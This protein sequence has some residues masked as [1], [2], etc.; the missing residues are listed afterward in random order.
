M[1]T[2]KSRAE[3]LEDIQRRRKELAALEE[4]A[5]QLR[6]TIE[7][8]MSLVSLFRLIPPEILKC[9]LGYLIEGDIHD[10]HSL[11]E[12]TE[13]VRRL[14]MVNKCWHSVIMRSP[15]FWTVCEFL[16]RAPFAKRSQKW[17]LRSGNL[18]LQASVVFMSDAYPQQVWR[19]ALKSVRSRISSLRLASPDPDLNSPYELFGWSDNLGNIPNLTHLTLENITQTPAGGHGIDHPPPTL[20][21]KSLTHFH[22]IHCCIFPL[23]EAPALQTLHCSN[24][25]RITASGVWQML[26]A[27][28]HIR[29]ISLCETTTLGPC[30]LQGTESDK[31]FAD[32]SLKHLRTLQLVPIPPEEDLAGI[33]N[34][35]LRSALFNNCHSS[36]SALQTLEFTDC[37]LNLQEPHAGEQPDL[38]LGVLDNLTGLTLHIDIYSS[39]YELLKA[40]VRLIQG[41]PCLESLALRG[42]NNSFGVFDIIFQCLLSPSGSCSDTQMNCPQLSTL[43]LDYGAVK[44]HAILRTLYKQRAASEPRQGRSR[45]LIK[46]ERMAI[47]GHPNEGRL[48]SGDWPSN[49]ENR[50]SPAIRKLFSDT[51]L[52][53]DCEIVERLLEIDSSEERLELLFNLLNCEG[54]LY[55]N[56]WLEDADT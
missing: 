41:C 1:S 4:A 16:E 33:V 21:L 20:Q 56:L 12:S 29:E 7:K 11:A 19:R 6:Q 38:L 24:D 52:A 35:E 26:A 14:M 53:G 2:S 49:S 36:K 46:L 54:S 22:L 15:T 31:N 23:I 17:I 55:R 3:I 43:T 9:I 34:P 30:P 18:P 44:W 48:Y 50:D 39:R 25:T 40:I 27:A 13:Q 32:I 37:Y 10:L 47:V 45:F 5:A 28:P 42:N 8:E 51:R